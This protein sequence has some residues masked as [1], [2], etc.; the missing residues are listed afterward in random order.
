MCERGREG[1]WKDAARRVMQSI[2]GSLGREVDFEV[3]VFWAPNLPEASAT[4]E[5]VNVF[6]LEVLVKVVRRGWIEVRDL[7]KVVPF[8]GGEKV[9]YVDYEG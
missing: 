3:L 5:V 9:G 7:E 6:L 1:D 4:K 8:G 2:M